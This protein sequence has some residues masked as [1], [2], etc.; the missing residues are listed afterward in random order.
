M[1]NGNTFIKAMRCLARADGDPVAAVEIARRDY[2]EGPVIGL[3]QKA[4]IVDTSDLGGDAAWRGAMAEFMAGAG[5]YD[6]LPR[7]DAISPLHTI[8]LRTRV[9]VQDEDPVA[10]WTGE[11]E[12]VVVSG[13]SFTETKVEPQ[14]ACGLITV[15]KEVV[16]LATDAAEASLTRSLQRAVAKLTSAAAFAAAPVPGAPASLLV[17]AVEVSSTGDV[18]AD[19][20]ALT[21]A[22]EGDIERAVLVMSSNT[23]MS[24][25]VQPSL[26]GSA[27]GLGVK[28]GVFCGL[29]VVASSALAD[30]LLALVDAGGIAYGD[31]GVELDVATQAD[32]TIDGVMH[33]LWAE[34]LVGYLARRFVA[35]QAAPGS[36]AYLSGAAWATAAAATKRKGHT[37]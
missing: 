20:A 22:F 10:L 24:L 9:L 1:I 11:G 18:R 30:G 21:A 27:A 23:A 37:P 29:P 25:C 36:I 5:F 6:L 13:A 8:P 12:P 7:I 31:G 35:W 34:N 2:S 3:L 28:G 17:D 15:T 26:V 14:K 19:M 33:S 16:A 4:V 32:V